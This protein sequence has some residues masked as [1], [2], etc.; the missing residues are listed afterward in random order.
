MSLTTIFNLGLSFQKKSST[1]SNFSCFVVKKICFSY[2]VLQLLAKIT[3]CSFK[4]HDLSIF[5]FLGADVF[6][7]IYDNLAYQCSDREAT[8][9]R[10]SNLFLHNVPSSSTFL[11][12]SRSNCGVWPSACS[13]YVGSSGHSGEFPINSSKCMLFLA[14]RGLISAVLSNFH[15]IELG[16]H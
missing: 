16:L 7:W 14:S 9:V 12:L 11:H 6:Y 10:S 15:H 5:R 2:V 8:R 1:A 13:S 4:D 3:P